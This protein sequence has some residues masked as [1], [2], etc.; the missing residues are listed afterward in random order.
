[1]KFW[2]PGMAR[3]FGRRVT[4]HYNP[5][6]LSS[7]SV[8]DAETRQPLGEAWR[9]NV[10]GARFTLEDVKRERLQFRAELQG[11]AERLPSYHASVEADDRK[12]PGHREDI[13]RKAQQLSN[14]SKKAREKKSDDN[15]LTAKAKTPRVPASS[16]KVV[17]LMDRLQRSRRG[18]AAR[19]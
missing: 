2:F 18:E 13:A 14:A 5:E 19:P 10:D 9:M 8:R 1:M 16:P 6:D 15:G 17:S 12:S 11:V 4:V 3:L 7:V